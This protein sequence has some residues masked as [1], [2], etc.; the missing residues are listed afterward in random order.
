MPSPIPRMSRPGW[1]A[2]RR[3][4]SRTV[5]NKRS[6]KSTENQGVRMPKGYIILTEDI[7]DPAGMAEYQVSWQGDGRLDSAVLRPEAR[8]AGGGVARQPDR[9][10]RVRVGR[11]RPRVVPL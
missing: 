2:P 10:S 11:G 3:R 8:G 5:L 9:R 1:R 4:P 7:K 6:A